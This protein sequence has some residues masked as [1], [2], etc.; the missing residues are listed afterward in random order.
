MQVSDSVECSDPRWRATFRVC[1]ALRRPGMIGVAVGRVRVNSKVTESE[2]LY[3]AQVAPL[4]NLP[5]EPVQHTEYPM[6]IYYS[7]N[8]TS[9]ITLSTEYPVHSCTRGSRRSPTCWCWVC[10]RQSNSK[11]GASRL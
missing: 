9:A 11:S 4:L 6:E 5:S 8:I 10:I 3:N 2:V 1:F 7:V